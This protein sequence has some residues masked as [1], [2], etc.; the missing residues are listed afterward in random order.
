MK[1][2]KQASLVFFLIVVG[3]PLKSPAG[4]STILKTI[5]Q[6]A[7]EINAAK[8]RMAAAR[9]AVKLAKSQ[10]W[11]KVTLFAQ[12]AHSNEL[13][14]INRNFPVT[15]D[16]NTLSYGANLSLPIDF[17]GR[18]TSQV[19]AK[20]A[21]QSAA[22]FSE[23]GIRL[24]LFKQSVTLYRGLQR[25]AG[26]KTALSK[27]LSALEEHQ[28]ITQAAIDAGRMSKVKLLQIQ[29]EV[30]NIKGKIA[31]VLGDEARLR[32]GLSALINQ[33]QFS[34][35]I[36]PLL[37]SPQPIAMV[38]IENELQTRPDIQA[39]LKV[40][41][42]SQSLVKSAKSE[43]LPSFA[44]QANA[45]RDKGYDT[46]TENSLS[47]MGV[48][49]WNLWDGGQR[50]ASIDQA[51]AKLQEADYKQRAAINKARAE[52]ISAQAAWQSAN[53][54]YAAAKIGVEAAEE[55]EKIQSDLYKNG[56]VSAVDLID[57]ESALALARANRASALANWWLADDQLMIVRGLAPSD[58]SK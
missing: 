30:Q 57:T 38:N 47:I 49:R 19:E 51:Q 25:L 42:A 33:N 15:L 18:I 43:W 34:E 52:L 11:G 6:D 12:D 27:Q 28:R 13:R 14:P 40:K 3:L 26:V 16:D 32:A 10:Y 31:G 54:Q 22:D 7:P 20:T 2:K 56:R 37:T 29:A 50:S 45:Q 8:A 9:S 48:V 41:E 5:E 1:L 23:K 17:N 35:A 46:V 55:T 24:A 39:S 44:I 4:L 53:Q 21:L 58:Y 36:D